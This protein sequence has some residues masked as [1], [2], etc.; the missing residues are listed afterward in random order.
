MSFGVQ[1]GAG[2]QDVLGPY[3]PPAAGKQYDPGSYGGYNSV[4]TY[5]NGYPVYHPDQSGMEDAASRYRGMGGQPVGIDT[6]QSSQTRGAQMGA[7]GLM[8]TAAQGSA[9]SQAEIL[10]RKANEDAMAGQMSMAASVKGG[11]A[12]QAA[13]MRSAMMGQASQAA[14]GN[15]EIAALRAQEMAQARG[16]YFGATSQARGQDIGEAQKQAELNEARQQYYEGMA[17]DVYKTQLNANLGKQSESDQAWYRGRMATLQSE[18]QDAQNAKDIASVGLGGL[19]GAMGSPSDVRSKEDIQPLRYGYFDPSE[20]GSARPS[21]LAFRD[22]PD[23]RDAM[24]SD[25]RAKVAE[26][27]RSAYLLGRAHSSE[28]AATGKPIPY[29]YGGPPRAGE[30]IK[31]AD[32]FLGRVAPPEHRNSAKEDAAEGYR[33]GSTAAG[34][35]G[36]M[37]GGAIGGL[38][39]VMERGMERAMPPQEAASAVRR[40][41]D[42][43]NALVDRGVAAGQHAATAVLGGAPPPTT[44]E[45]SPPS[46]SDERT[47]QVLRREEPMAEA[48]RALEASAYRYR[49]EYTPRGQTPGE[50]N[51]GPMAQNMARDPVARTAIVQ[52]GPDGML[53]IDKEKGLKLALGG[54]ASLQ[55]QVDA[56]AGK[57][58]RTR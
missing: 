40:L 2:E 19:T 29:S 16:Q 5:E 47:K 11:P 6:T 14:A 1:S 18:A 17:N 58:K 41:R 15:R 49:P 23:E 25:D 30:D 52:G 38:S 12:A 9:P 42:R 51:V 55:H 37:V 57:M 8:Q 43:T 35:A 33:I 28:A 22:F 48:N 3:I 45:A 46:L 20:G 53:A 31:D 27:Q 36:G 34:P 44:A 56:I 39:N 50:L 13:A 10:S 32:P 4:V 24:T 26:A 54:L 21:D 7:L